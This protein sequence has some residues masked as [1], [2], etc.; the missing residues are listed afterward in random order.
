MN[1]ALRPQKP[2]NP[3]NWLHDSQEDY[4]RYFTKLVYLG[5]NAPEWAECTNLEREEF[6]RTH[7]APEQEIPSEETT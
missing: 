1:N 2:S 4:T 5:V 3:D 6:E 7:P